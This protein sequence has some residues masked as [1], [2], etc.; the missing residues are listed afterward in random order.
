MWR[1]EGF[2]IDPRSIDEASTMSQICIFWHTFL[3]RDPPLW[4]LLQIA[5]LVKT[6]RRQQRD[7]CFWILTGRFH[8]LNCVFQSHRRAAGLFC[9]VLD[10]PQ[11]GTMFKSLKKFMSSNH[12]LIFALF[13][14]LKLFVVSAWIVRYCQLQWLEPCCCCPVEIRHQDMQWCHYGSRVLSQLVML[15]EGAA[16][17]QLCGRRLLPV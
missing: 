5:I 2:Q 15:C 1:F 7:F 17:T 11:Q 12:Q 3:R 14:S 10:Y 6:C 8:C 16:R 9:N 13:F 4:V